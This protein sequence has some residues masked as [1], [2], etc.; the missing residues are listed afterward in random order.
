MTLA[1]C[2][3]C[4]AIFTPT[5]GAHQPSCSFDTIPAPPPAGVE[6][7]CEACTRLE[8]YSRVHHLA[9]APSCPRRVPRLYDGG[10]TMTERVE[11]YAAA[12]GIRLD[13]GMSWVEFC[14]AVQAV[15][16]G[17]SA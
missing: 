13:P 15:R 10:G 5:S 3:D 8:A 17:R 2:P 6:V 4:F 11:R 14:L 7:P 16:E 9:H 1:T 12:H